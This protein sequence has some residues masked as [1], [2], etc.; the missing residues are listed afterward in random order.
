MA[1]LDA[2]HGAVAAVEVG[3]ALEA[4]NLAIIPDARAAMGDA[5][6]AGDAGGLDEGGAET[7]GR[8]AGVMFEMPVLHAALDRLVLAHRR[9]YDAIAQRDAAQG[10]RRE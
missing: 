10:E 8:E 4:G 2:G 9:H 5:A 1:D 3:D 6:V 7:A